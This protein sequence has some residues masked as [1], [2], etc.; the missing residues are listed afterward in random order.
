MVP[1]LRS[2]RDRLSRRESVETLANEI[3]LPG[4]H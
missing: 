1:H 3:E 4:G 2:L